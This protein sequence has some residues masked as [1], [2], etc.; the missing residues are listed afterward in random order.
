MAQSVSIS[1]MVVGPCAYLACSRG[2][3]GLEVML[4]CS[5]T[6]FFLGSSTMEP[7]AEEL[8]T[9]RTAKDLC[10][11]AELVDAE[12]AAASPRRTFLAALGATENTKLFLLAAIPEST[13]QIIMSEWQI[14]NLKPTAIH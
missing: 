8:S 7:T 14:G 5:T 3:F 12:E 4:T 11:W 6:W 10:D 13:W 2:H 9:F 1:G